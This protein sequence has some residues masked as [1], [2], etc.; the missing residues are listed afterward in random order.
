LQTGHRRFNNYASSCVTLT[1]RRGVEHRKL[2]TRFGV[3]WRV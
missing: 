2:V 3:I 1:L